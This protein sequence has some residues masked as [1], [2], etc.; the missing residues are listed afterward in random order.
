MA[1]GCLG[2]VAA[3]CVL[4]LVGAFLIAFLESGSATGEMRLR[5][6]ATY[7]PGTVEFVGE[8]NLFLVRLPAGGFLAL[9]DLDAANRAAQGRRC[10][11][12][13]AAGGTADIDALISRYDG[14][15]S[16]D[17][18]GAR[19]V[20]REDCDGAV[21]DIAGKRLDEAGPNLD[22][23]AV[24]VDSSNRV[25]VDLSKR[26]CSEAAEGETFHAVDCRLPR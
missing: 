4:I 16:A 13:L 9:A 14:N 15:F 21:Y 19:A 1:L 2:M 26:T 25:V 17:A 7:A 18:A 3:A 22:R 10:R 20:F 24:I 11:V 23:Y 8:R 12:Q 6:A 5:P